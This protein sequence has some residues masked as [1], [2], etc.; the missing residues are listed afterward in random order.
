MVDGG[1]GH[2]GRNSPELHFGLGANVS[3]QDVFAVEIIWRNSKG[4]MN[5]SNIDVAAGWHNL[6][7]PY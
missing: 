2:S 3:P 4:E 6:Y 1:N 7:L 5:K